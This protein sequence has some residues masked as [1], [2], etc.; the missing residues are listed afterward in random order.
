MKQTTTAA[1]L[2]AAT[3][4][5]IERVIDAPRELVFEAWTRPEHLVHWWAPRG[6][7]TP[8]YTVDLRPGGAFHYCMRMA[9]GR[10]IWGLGIFREV[11]R[12]EKIVYVDS[13][14]D[15]AGGKVPPSR[16]GMSNAHPAESLVTVSFSDLGGRTRVV[17]RH[18]LPA[19]FP[20]R[21]GVGQGW[22]EM[23]DRLAEHLLEGGD[24]APDARERELVATRVFDAPRELVFRMW[25]DPRHV[26]QW[27]GPRGFTNTILEMDVKPGGVW[28]LIMHG[29]D[30]RDYPNR[31]VF[32]LVVE[33]ELLA[34]THSADTDGPPEVF[35]TTVTFAAE[36]HR[37]RLTMRMV[38]ASREARDEMTRKYGADKG[39]VETLDRLGEYVVAASR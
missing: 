2:G 11:V 7:S 3:D 23:M 4:I 35:A 34:Y 12:P 37:T 28:R 5:V 16:Y 24:G 6:C 8:A 15:E 20:E 22:G 32:D 13:F 27:W 25:T 29:P 36:G 21:S 30:G 38:F 33:P 10:D 17:L 18:S 1:A 26:A 14:A 9:D 19:A 31:I 39:L